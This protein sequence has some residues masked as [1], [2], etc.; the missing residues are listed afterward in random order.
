MKYFGSLAN[1]NVETPPIAAIQKIDIRVISA[2]KTLAAS[3][4]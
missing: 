4:N 1:I 2:A 3:S